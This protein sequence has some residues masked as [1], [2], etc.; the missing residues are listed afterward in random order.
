MLSLLESKRNDGTQ[1]EFWDLF[2][3]ISPKNKKEAVFPS[4]KKFFDHFQNL[5]NFSRSQNIPGISE[6]HDPLDYEI[7]LKELETSSNK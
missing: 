2:R 4:R 5:S 7:S 1:K 3:K 6:V